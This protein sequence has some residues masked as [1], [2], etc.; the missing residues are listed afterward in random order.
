MIAVRVDRPDTET[1]AVNTLN[2]YGA[3]DIERT[4]G[5]WKAGDWKDFDPRVPSPD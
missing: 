5:T 3:R 4:E 2:R 1:R